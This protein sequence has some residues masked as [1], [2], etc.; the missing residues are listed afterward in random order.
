MLRVLLLAALVLTAH[1][2]GTKGGK[3]AA[4]AQQRPW[5]ATKQPAPSEEQPREAA[6]PNFVE[7]PPPPNPGKPA[8]GRVPIFTLSL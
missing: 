5:Y 4:A 8:H 2:Q 1:G 3:T 6:L 7:P